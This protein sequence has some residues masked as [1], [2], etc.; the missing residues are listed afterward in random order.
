[1][2]SSSKKAYW[3]SMS[4]RYGKV[5]K[6]KAAQHSALLDIHYLPSQVPVNTLQAVISVIY[7]EALDH[8]RIIR[9]YFWMHFVL[10]HEVLL[11]M[12]FLTQRRRNFND[13]NPCNLLIM[14]SCWHLKK[15]VE[16]P[17]CWCTKMV[18]KNDKK[19]HHEFSQKK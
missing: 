7:L 14:P 1:M 10:S 16:F 17:S 13:A 12:T 9:R 5:L 15:N 8:R 18:G 6:G 3:F 11:W 19:H 4:L 2:I